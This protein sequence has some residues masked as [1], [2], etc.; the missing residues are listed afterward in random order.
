MIIKKA[1]NLPSKD[2]KLIGKG[3]SDPYCYVYLTSNPDGRQKTSTKK[4]TLEP[5]WDESF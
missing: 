5:E 4:E 1:K 3:S 2:V